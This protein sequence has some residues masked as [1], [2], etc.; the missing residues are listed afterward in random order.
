MSLFI[1]NPIKRGYYNPAESWL[2]EFF[3]TSHGKTSQ[4]SGVKANVIE[5]SDQYEVQVAAP[6][7]D[8]SQ[9][10]VKVEDDQL[11]ITGTIENTEEK[12]E[13][14]VRR[15]EFSVR[16]FSRS[17]SLNDSINVDTIKAVYENGVLKVTVPKK[18]E[19]K[20]E[21]KLIEIS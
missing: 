2:N 20:Q 11:I 15:R 16:N 1:A 21:S 7:F 10:N 12:A 9:F 4:S 17:Y 19:V 18:E 14:E 6:G 8:K 3:P 5:H 13:G